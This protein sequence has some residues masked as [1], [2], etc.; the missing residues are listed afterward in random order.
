VDGVGSYLLLHGVLVFLGF[1]AATAGLFLAFLS[2]RYWFARAW[3]FAG[4][5]ERPEWRK[6]I[7]GALIAALVAVALVAI[8]AVSR[9][10]R[11]VVSRGSWWAAFF[12]LWLSSSIF[13]YLFIKLIAAAEWV[14]KRVRRSPR[15]EDANPATSPAMSS[16]GAHAERIDHSRRYFFQAAGVIAG[17]VPFVSASYGF[18]SERFRFSVREVDIPIANLP[19]ALDGLR[20]TQISDLHAGSYMPVQQVRRAIGMANELKGDLAVVTGDFISDRGD[21]LEDCITEISRLR[22]PLGVWGCNG[23]H[24]IYAHAEAASAALFQRFG[25]KLLR[26]ENAEL[27]WNGGA[28][29]LI[30]V[31]YQRQHPTEGVHPPM[32]AGVQALVR[33]DIPNIMLSHNPNSFP[34]AAELGIELSLAG[35]THGG[36]VRVEILDHCWSPAEFLTPYVAGLYRRPL[37]A[38]AILGDNEIAGFHQASN[39]QSPTSSIYVNRGLGTIGA[40]VRLGVPPEIT[41]ITLR[42]AV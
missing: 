36:Q 12:G 6:K 32:L 3:R 34:K 20:I 37:L 17:A 21:P 16:A 4:R 24:E 5:I 15:A 8:I 33:R 10:M 23:N 30:G 40:P 1:L 25:M 31:D 38:P 19:P 9:N 22:A 18:V 13:S 27:R 29:N 26:H 42:R 2:Q 41:L 35:H 14:W 28:L 7:R 11:G 39:L